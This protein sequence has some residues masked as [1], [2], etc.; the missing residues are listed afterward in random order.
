MNKNE[1]YPWQEALWHQFT[2]DTDHLHHAMLIHGRS[3]IGKLNFGKALSKRLLCR[4]GSG[5]KACGCCPSCVWFEEQTNPDFK[6]V[7]PE[8]GEQED[9]TV[10][11]AGK[12]TQISIE[13]IRQL[14]QWMSLTNHEASGKRIALIYPAETLNQASANAL[15]KLLEEPP[16]NSYFILITHQIKRLLPTVVSRCQTI[17]MTMPS[18][19]ISIDW[20]KSQGVHQ[21]EEWLAYYGGAPI[22]VLAQTLSGETAHTSI[23]K[24]LSL[25]AKIDI[26]TAASTMIVHGADYAF[27]AVQKWVYDLELVMFG[28]PIYYHIRFSNALQSLAKSVNLQRLLDLQ[29]LIFQMKQ[30]S[31]HPL[32]QEM[33]LE[34]ILLQY[35]H[36]FVSR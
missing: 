34:Q 8:E 14:T 16:Q 12:R 27:S 6:L 25:G 9:N 5:E 19:S 13:Q 23:V 29:R 17:S 35:Q 32:N 2:R 21:A 22:N 18:Q 4:D 26:F 20:L 33:Q 1:Y 10:K 7:S 3:G 11:K 31:N 24:Q 15:L 28:L 30:T 36:I